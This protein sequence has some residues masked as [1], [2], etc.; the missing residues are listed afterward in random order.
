MTQV[1][2]IKKPPEKHQGVVYQALC[3]PLILAE[4]SR[5]LG[6]IDPK[7]GGGLAVL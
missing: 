1:K 4:I 3:S 7:S 5:L 6:R 2:S